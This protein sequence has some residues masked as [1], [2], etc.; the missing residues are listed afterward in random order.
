MDNVGVPCAGEP[1]AHDRGHELSPTEATPSPEDGHE[2]ISTIHEHS[3]L[4]RSNPSTWFTL[5]LPATG[6]CQVARAARPSS[7]HPEQRSASI[8]RRSANALLGALPNAAVTDAL[9]RHDAELQA[10]LAA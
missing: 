1:H 3:M 10:T 7:T 6:P 5:H 9:T 2:A 4:T 8:A